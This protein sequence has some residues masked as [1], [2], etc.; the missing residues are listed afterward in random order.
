MVSKRRQRE[1]T[2]ERR[3][4]FSRSSLSPEQIELLKPGR[5]VVLR[6]ARVDMFKG[7]MRLAVDKWG[8]IEA[9]TDVNFNVNLNNNLSAIEYELV[10]ETEQEQ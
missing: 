2:R 4:F 8:K 1:E 10:N 5:T 9:A 6:N 3:Q 7:Y